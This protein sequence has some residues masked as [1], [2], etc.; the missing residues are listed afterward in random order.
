MWRSPSLAD[1]HRPGALVLAGRGLRAQR[2]RRV[3]QRDERAALD[4]QDGVGRAER[5]PQR[6]LAR[7]RR[8]T[9]SCCRS[10][11][12]RGAGRVERLGATSTAPRAR[13]SVGRAPAGPSAR[14]SS[15]RARRPDVD[16][17]AARGRPARDRRRGAGADL[18]LGRLLPGD[19]ALA[20][21]GRARPPDPPSRV[22]HLALDDMQEAHAR[23]RRAAP[24]P[25]TRHCVCIAHGRR[26]ARALCAA[27]VDAA[28]RPAPLVLEGR[29]A[30]RPQ[31]V[32][33]VEDRVGD[34]ADGVHARISP[35]PRAARPRLLPARRARA[36]PGR[37]RA[38]RTCRGRGA[39]RRCPGSSGRSPRATP[40]TGS[41]Q[42]ASRS[43]AISAAC[44]R[45]PS[46]A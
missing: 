33:L 37:R 46:P 14:S 36:A 20:V 17:D 6:L 2:G 1:Q 21:D 45:P 41:R 23:R 26:G 30:V 43:Q 11:R 13:A 32:A 7:A 5:P 31:H 28:E 10:A 18:A 27:R 25:S 16:R 9:A 4:A 15:S 22:A 42:S 40:R 34:R 29:A 8:P 44:S 3:G 12:S 24:R 19:V 38:G 35:P 39:A